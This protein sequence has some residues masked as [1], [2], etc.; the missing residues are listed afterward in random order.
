MKLNPIKLTQNETKFLKLILDKGNISDAEISKKTGISKSTCSRIRKKIESTLIKEYL[1]IIELDKVGI[2]VF[3]VIIFK[4]K[5]FDNE[6]LTKKTFDNF[7][8]D[9]HVI[10]LANGEGSGGLSTVM[11]MGFENLDQYHSYFKEFRKNYDKYI[12][13]VNT[14]MLPSKKVIKN[15]YTEIIKQV[16]LRGGKE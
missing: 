15:D 10:F 3:L 7:D 5:A 12:N 11:F 6:T 9:S 13:N 1:P 4:W 16:L 8:K 14:L 2:E